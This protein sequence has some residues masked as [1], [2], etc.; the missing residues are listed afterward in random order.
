M[1]GLSMSHVCRKRE[2][3]KGIRQPLYA[4]AAWD[5]VTEHL[6]KC[7]PVLFTAQKLL[8]AAWQ[9]TSACSAYMQWQKAKAQAKRNMPQAENEAARRDI[10][11]EV[12]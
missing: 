3:N 4:L 11:R 5:T 7:L 9:Q 10:G 12:L 6:H 8:P 2:G 1:C